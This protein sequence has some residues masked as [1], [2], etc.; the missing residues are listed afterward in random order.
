MLAVPCPLKIK[1]ARPV[2][3]RSNPGSIL[4]PNL[5]TGFANICQQRSVGFGRHVARKKT[6]DINPPYS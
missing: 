4:H 6:A 2:W 3:Q 5:I 1:L